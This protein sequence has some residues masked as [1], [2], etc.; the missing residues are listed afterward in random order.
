[1]K[2]RDEYQ[3]PPEGV[4]LGRCKRCNAQVYLVQVAG[5]DDGA[6]VEVDLRR[7]VVATNARQL[8]PGRLLHHVTCRVN[9][10]AQD[11]KK[12]KALMRKI[13][14]ATRNARRGR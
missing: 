14:K 9:A 5:R 1:M 2:D 8:V 13:R 4:T 3:A 12:R 7:V 11:R 10:D 6:E